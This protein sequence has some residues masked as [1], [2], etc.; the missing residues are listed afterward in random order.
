[1]TILT[2]KVKQCGEKFWIIALF[3]FENLET[4]ALKKNNNLSLTGTFKVFSCDSS[5][6][7]PNKINSSFPFDNEY[8]IVSM[9]ECGLK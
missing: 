9:G 4:Q 7:P 8:K 1:M 6:M 5:S 2:K 3:L